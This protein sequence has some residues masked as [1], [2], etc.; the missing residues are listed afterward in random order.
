MENDE[1]GYEVKDKRRV[2]ADGTLREDVDDE[3][4]TARD[5]QVEES[6]EVQSETAETAD[7]EA[8]DSAGEEEFESMLPPDVY[9]MLQFTFGMFAEQ[10]WV[11]M[12]I[13]LAPGQKELTKD[14]TQ[15]KIAID[16]ASVIADKLHPHVQEESR[17]MM[18]SIV[19][20]LQINFVRQSS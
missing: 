11:H 7:A 6:A 10:A 14:L 1:R 3:P 16:M 18:R 8:E 2:N 15:A 17:K 9:A 12:G 13:R 5:E 20:D 4:E 19:S